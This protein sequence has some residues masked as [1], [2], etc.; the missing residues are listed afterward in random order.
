MSSQPPPSPP[1]PLPCPFVRPI[2][3]RIHLRATNCRAAPRGLIPP[4][5]SPNV[6][7]TMLGAASLWLPRPHSAI[8]STACVCRHARTGSSPPVSSL[9]RRAATADCSPAAAPGLAAT[10]SVGG[11]SRSAFRL[12]RRIDHVAASHDTRPSRAA[13]Y[14]YPCEP[15]KSCNGYRAASRS[16][17]R[18]SVSASS[19]SR[20]RCDCLAFRRNHTEFQVPIRC[21]RQSRS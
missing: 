2:E 14:C 10:F 5:A 12:V 8:G 4:T 6:V 13:A 20:Y 18:R 19:L 7:A 11:R 3:R 16:S 9:W 15:N 21:G 1:Q 17:P